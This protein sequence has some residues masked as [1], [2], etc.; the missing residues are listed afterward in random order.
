[1]F[2]APCAHN[3][4]AKLYYIESGIVT[5]VGDRPV[6]RLRAQDGHLQVWWYQMVYNTILTAW[7][8]AHSAQNIQRHIMNLL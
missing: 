3:Q 2:R 7:W 6:H 8:W 4:E 5:P 1:M